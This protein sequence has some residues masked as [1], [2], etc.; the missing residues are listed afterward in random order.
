EH[1]PIVGAMLADPRVTAV[2]AMSAP[3]PKRLD[4]AALDHI[5]MP[6]FCMTGTRDNSPIGETTAA[7]RRLLFDRM[8]SP[9]AC[10]LTFNGADHMTFSGRRQQTPDDSRFQ[11]L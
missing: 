7:Q 3:V 9:D 6:V 2:I 10:L 1:Q 4:S 8:T 11:K 5:T